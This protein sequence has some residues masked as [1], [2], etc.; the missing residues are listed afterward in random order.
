[1]DNKKCEML[2]LAPRIVTT[3]VFLIINVSNKS[4]NYLPFLPPP[5]LQAIIQKFKKLLIN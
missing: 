5:F 1:M 4:A 2:F 3:N